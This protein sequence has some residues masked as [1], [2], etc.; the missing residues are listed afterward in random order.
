VRAIPTPVRRGAAAHAR[1]IARRRAASL[2]RGRVV[3]LARGR[4]ASLTRVV[5]VL[6]LVA[7][8]AVALGCQESGFD[9]RKETARPLKVQHALG[10]TKVP[11]QSSRPLMLTVDSLDDTLA[12]G[13]R[14]VRTAA[15][16]RELPAYLRARAAGIQV[17]PPLVTRGQLGAL[18]AARPD[19]IICSAAQRRLYM[20]LNDIAP[21][22]ATDT[23][24]VQWKLNLRQVGEALGRTNEAEKLLID[25]DAWSARVRHVVHGKPRVAVVREG[26][27][28]PV[29]AKRYSFAG[30]ILSDVGVRQVRSPKDAD[31][32]IRGDTATWWGPGGILEARAALADL[33]PRLEALQR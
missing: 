3:S 22:V 15:P 10:E 4:A 23:G 2:A 7:S 16:G 19:L 32:V 27:N 8:A 28:G 6:L 12:L 17:L 18:E 20:D 24:S 14:P 9:E 29:A 21:T 26:A 13:V 11:G 1:A 31:I 25:Y 30:T 33:R 5:T